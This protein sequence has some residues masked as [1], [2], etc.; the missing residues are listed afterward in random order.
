[1]GGSEL[2][3]DGL[4]TAHEWQNDH[5]EPNLRLRIEPCRRCLR[6]A[7]E[8]A[9]LEQEAICYRCNIYEIGYEEG[10]GFGCMGWDEV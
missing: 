9:H 8:A 1:M 7:A 4:V 6:A 2:E 3:L 10:A 5:W